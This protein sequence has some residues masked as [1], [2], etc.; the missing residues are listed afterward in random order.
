MNTYGNTTG[1]I[2]NLADRDARMLNKIETEINNLVSRI[3]TL[4][5]ATTH[6]DTTNLN[7]IVNNR[8]SLVIKNILN[9]Y[10]IGH[11]ERRKWCGLKRFTIITFNNII[12]R[13]ISIASHESHPV[14]LEHIVSNAIDI[15]S[16]HSHHTR[17]GTGTGTGN[18]TGSS[19]DNRNIDDKHDYLNPANKAQARKLRGFYNP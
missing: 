7:L 3:K 12:P 5:R 17:S 19:N 9:Q 14:P 8:L 2:R 11:F 6:I 13:I 10:D 1:S 15:K 4:Q 18:K 16:P